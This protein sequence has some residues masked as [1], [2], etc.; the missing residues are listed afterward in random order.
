MRE[1]KFSSDKCGLAK[2]NKAISTILRADSKAVF[3]LSERGISGKACDMFECA[4]LILP[5]GK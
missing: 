5:K 1:R 4:V 3:R 2:T